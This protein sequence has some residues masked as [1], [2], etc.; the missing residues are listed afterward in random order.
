MGLLIGMG[1]I[2]SQFAF[3]DFYGVEWDITVSNPKLTRIGKDELHKSLPVQSRMR[4]CILTDDGKVNYYLDANNST[5][6]DN[7]TAANLDGSH[8]M[9]MVE[10]PDTYVRFEADGNKRRCLMSDKALPGF[11]KW[12]KDYVSAYEATVERA[13]SKLACV[14]NK[15]AAFRGGN[16]SEIHDFGG[17]TFLGKPATNISLT[18]FRKYARNR[19]S[20]EWNCNTYHIHRKLWWL[21]AVEYANFNSQD[22]F[23]AQLTSNG[24][25][26]GG[27]SNGVTNLSSTSISCIPCG[28]TNK[29]G[30]KTGIVTYTMPLEYGEIGTTNVPSYR[31]VENI[32]GHLWKWTDGCKCMAYADSDKGVSEFYVC[33]NP[34]N[35]TSSGITNYELRGYLPRA[36]GYVKEI[37]LGEYGEIVPLTVGAGSTTYFCD[38]FYTDTPSS[39]VYE[40]SPSFGGGVLYGGAD[41][42]LAC[43]AINSTESSLYPYM[44]SRLCF[45]PEVVQIL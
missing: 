11:I 24:Y 23:N 41:A 22:N 33:D 7:S 3:D 38:I 1:Q 13:T 29:L 30:N 37:I 39:G 44:G 18:D 20:V 40:L 2:K 45:I 12:S 5:L 14:V 42:G 8:G 43:V 26:Q 28:T 35:Y 19:G 9:V 21:Y 17:K 6:R 25:R 36:V 31:G 4:R 27:L 16:N 32:F 15:T 34:A 10:L